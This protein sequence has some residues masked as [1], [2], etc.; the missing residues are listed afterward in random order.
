MINCCSSCNYYLLTKELISII[1][2]LQ[3]EDIDSSEDNINKYPWF[4]TY[5]ESG[6]EGLKNYLGTNN[7]ID[8]DKLTNIISK[9]KSGEN[10]IYLKRMGRQMHE[11][12]YEAIDFS[13]IDVLI[14]EWT[15]GNSDNYSGVDIP[16]LLNSTPSETLAH[17]KSRNRDGAVDAPFITM[18][19]GL[20]QEM[21]D[22]QAS[23]AKV[24]LSK[25]GKVLTYLE[26]KDI[27]TNN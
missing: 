2:K 8:F 24:I 19:L 14:I 21:L 10:S 9:F 4:S 17:R 22:K 20:E 5:I 7:E 18:V 16:V 25:T 11:L 27:M 13:N 3:K 15:H 23:K 6:K 1:S 26:Y 12:W